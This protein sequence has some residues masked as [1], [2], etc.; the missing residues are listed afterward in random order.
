FRNDSADESFVPSTI[1]LRRS[2]FLI[3]VDI[4]M[5]PSSLPP[6]AG[7]GL[8][9]VIDYCSALKK[10]LNSNNPLSSKGEKA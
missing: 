9:C 3:A 1:S 8:C 5:V 7:E 10:I 4:L 6:G 2:S